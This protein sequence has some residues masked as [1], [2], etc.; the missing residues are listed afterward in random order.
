MPR[1]A[2]LS[3]LLL[4]LVAASPSAAEPLALA[5]PLGEEQP[6]VVDFDALGAAGTRAPGRDDGAGGWDSYWSLRLRF[7]GPDEQYDSLGLPGASSIDAYNGG[8]PDGSD[9]ALGLYTNSSGNPT[10]QLTM[11]LRNASGSELSHFY[12]LFDV[13]FWLQRSRGRWAG[14]QA[15]VSVDGERYVDLGDAFEATLVNTE[16]DSYPGWVDGNAAQNA[17]RDL[18]GRVDLRA[19]GLAPVP[20]GGDLYL[21]FD[22]ARGLTVPEGFSQGQNRNN[23]AF[24][25]DVRVSLEPFLEPA[26]EVAAVPAAPDPLRVALVL[27][28]LIAARLVAKSA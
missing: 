13:E 21:R 4:A 2:P 5:Y 11:R 27:S 19:L 22:G 10:R 3:A 1:R 14:L 28:L 17:R 23:A 16:H 20:D 8:A 9:R 25:D 18:G 26:Q 12:L 15:F 7:A 6:V 24:L